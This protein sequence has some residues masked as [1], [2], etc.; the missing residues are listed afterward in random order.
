MKTK[1]LILSL[2]CGLFVFSGQQA[3]ANTYH[4]NQSNT[5]TNGLNYVQTDLVK[6]AKKSAKDENKGKDTV[7]DVKK[8][9]NIAKDEEKVIVKNDDK[10][11]AKDDYKDVAKDENKGKETVKD[12]KKDNDIA[13]DE[14]K[15][16]VKNDDKDVAK[17]ENKGKDTVK[18]V[19]KDEVKSDVKDNSE[20]GTNP[21]SFENLVTHNGGGND[22]CKSKKGNECNEGD[23]EDSHHNDDDDEHEISP[24]PIPGAIWLFGTALV[25]FISMN[26][27]RKV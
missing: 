13:K 12:V 22:H 18:D 15:V 14:E 27:R 5:P 1:N 19:K 7:K 10:D 2:L 24:V 8:D 21:L 17:D 6:L 20:D 26:S 11:V 25:G 4:P 16:V 9:N 23:D 3:Y